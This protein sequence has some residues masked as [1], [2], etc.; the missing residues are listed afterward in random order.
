MNFKIT[1]LLLIA[2]LSVSISPIIA[3]MLVNVPAVSI[4]FW[5]M[6]I[7]SLSLWMLSVFF[8]Q[9][10]FQDKSNF[11]RTILS[12]I[13]LGVHF[14]LFFQ[15]IKLTYIANATFLG[16]L[17]PL[18]TLIFEIVFLKRKFKIQFILVEPNL[19]MVARQKRRLSQFSGIKIIWKGKNLFK[20]T[21]TQF[22]YLNTTLIYKFR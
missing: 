3:K 14:V 17:A 5:R 11:H 9:G 7:G 1:I 13:L 19:A 4:S 16:T 22:F 2:L 10:R 15:A 20:P 8:N 21:T 12:G 6:F 18:F